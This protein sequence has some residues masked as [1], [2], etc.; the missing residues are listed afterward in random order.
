MKPVE[1]IADILLIAACI[2]GLITSV[3][4]ILTI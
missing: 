2:I 3:F 1:K 4:F